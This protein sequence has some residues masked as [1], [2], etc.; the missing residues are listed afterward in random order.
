MRPRRTGGIEHFYD[1]R[2]LAMMMFLWLPFLILIPV[3]VVW[4]LRPRGGMMGCGVAAHSA[5]M[6]P[7]GPGGPNPI[8]IARQR[9]ARGEITTAEF[10][11]IRR[12]IS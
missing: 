3:V 8:D 10:D 1:E 4:A 12:A 7:S 5:P 9:L 2:V 11:E 6:Q